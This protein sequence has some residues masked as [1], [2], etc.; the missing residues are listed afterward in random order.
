ME[1]FSFHFLRPL[2]LL[3]IPAALWLVWIWQRQTDQRRQWADIIAPHLLDH[4]IVGGKQGFRLR[5][6]HMIAGAV[7]LAGIATAGPV[8]E[9]EP[10]PFT[11]DKAPMVVAIDLSRTMDA[12]DVPP[13]RLERAK[14]KVRDLAALR[15]GSRT[16]LIVYAGTAHLVLPPTEDPA[17]LE[18]FLA[19]L[20]TDLMPVAGRN[21]DAALALADRLLTKETAAGTVLFIT[22]EFD[23]KQVPLLAEHQRQSRD[24]IL[25]LAVGTSQGGPIR[26]KNG[27]VAL[28]GRGV[29]LQARFDRET[30]TRMSSEADMPVMS[31][32]LDDADVEWVQRRA[33]HYL[34]VVNE[35]TAEVRWK[36]FGYYATFPLALLAAFWFR[37]GWTVRWMGV[38]V[39]VILMGA[40]GPIG[41]DAQESSSTK[42]E[43]PN[44]MEIPNHKS[45]VS[46]RATHPDASSSLK[47]GAW[48]LGFSEVSNLGFGAWILELVE[49]WFFTRD[50]QGRWY[51]DHGNYSTAAERFTDPMWKGL[52]S[53]RSGDY[54]A[55]LTQFARLDTPEAFFLM[56]NCYA[57]MKEFPAAVGAY[58]HALKGRPAFREATENRA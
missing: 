7:I 16:G 40:A 33:L 26:T 55:A 13:T 48:S 39:L 20:E 25:A 31:V 51:F 15:S 14:Q 53:Y 19:A 27:R 17:L 49:G 46:N 3:S 32:T 4:L 30:F 44:S 54:A 24:Q 21:A 35:R 50:Q 36:E 37:R 9:R 23:A 47:F 56:G 6:M 1:L 43:A 38:V 52:A 10:P 2:W 57:R 42:F 41:A 58:D 34:Q 45:Q 5:P 18:I 12:V 8:W 22:D 28:D 11:E 29:P